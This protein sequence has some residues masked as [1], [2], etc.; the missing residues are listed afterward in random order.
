MQ[1]FYGRGPVFF[2]WSTAVLGTVM[3]MLSPIATA[4]TRMP[5]VVASVALLAVGVVVFGVCQL[6]R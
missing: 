3:L 4:D 1:K 5:L 6:R 2:A